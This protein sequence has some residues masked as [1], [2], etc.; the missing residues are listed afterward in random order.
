MTSSNLSKIKPKLR[1]QGA[2]TGNFG[3]AKTKAGSPLR[4]IGKTK[5]DVVRI[6]QRSEYVK[7]MVMVWRTSSD[8]KMRDFAYHELHRLNCFQE[9]RIEGIRRTAEPYRGPIGA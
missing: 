4:E 8:P 1:T 3:H 9:R 7:R 2:L 6:T 5:A